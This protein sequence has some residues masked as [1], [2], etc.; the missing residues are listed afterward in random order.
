MKN[1]EF[2]EDNSGNR[3]TNNELNEFKALTIEK[4]NELQYYIKLIGDKYEDEENRKMAIDGAL[5]LFIEDAIMQVSS[6]KT[7]TIRTY[8]MRKYL[9]RLMALKYDKVVIEYYDVTYLTKLQLGADGKYRCTATIYQRFKGYSG[10]QLVYTDN[11][12]KD[13]EV[14]LEYKDDSFYKQKRWTLLLGDVEVSETS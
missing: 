4:V 11:T 1:L 9:F 12:T 8:P 10:D 5:K 14:I 2:V 6:N 13:V 7:G 3:L